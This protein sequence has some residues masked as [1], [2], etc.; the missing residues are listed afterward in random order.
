VTGHPHSTTG[1]WLF[2]QATS[3]WRDLSIS[4]VLSVFAAG[5]AVIASWLM[6][7]FGNAMFP[8]SVP[9]DGMG[10]L[11]DRLFTSL[12]GP[13]TPLTLVSL[14][15]GTYLAKNLFEY[16][17]RALSEAASL[18][19]E[20]RIRS[21]TWGAIW[22]NGSAHASGDISHAL[23][24]DSAEAASA[25]AVGPA[26][27]VG[28]PLTAMGYLL[29]LFWISP[30]L[31]GVL[32]V[33]VPAGLLL[34]RR[35]VRS[36]ARHADRRARSRAALGAAMTELLRFTRV[37]NAHWQ[38]SWAAD[39]TDHHERTVVRSATQWMLRVR[40]VPAVAEALAAFA[41]ALL[42]WLGIRAIAGGG[43][44][45]SE[46]L[47]FLTALFLLLPVVK[48]L[49]ALTGDL[50]TALSA[51]ER[52]H[53][54]MS[55]T[56]ATRVTRPLSRPVEI[57][58]DS[59]HVA[60]G[61]QSILNGVSFTADAG[62]MLAIHGPTGAGKTVLLEV[63]AGLRVPDSG[64]V[65]WNGGTVVN[66]DG[67]SMPS[68]VG[69]VPQDS[70]AVA[71]TIAENVTL[72][73]DISEDDVR[74]ALQWASLD[75]DPSLS[76]GEGGKPLSGG[77]RQRLAIARALAG[78]PAVLILDEPTS[79][80]DTRTTEAVMATLT[81]AGETTVIISSHDQLVHAAADRTLRLHDGRILR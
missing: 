15:C 53:A 2:T 30:G 41:G 6:V 77:E 62:E 19:I 33:I 4:L 60:D 65:T 59:L 3:Q 80:L 26:R 71:G 21:K 73:R 42:I 12:F 58:V 14:L 51:A 56:Q 49:G 32:L 24:I 5:V 76:I 29:T 34:T 43:V 23:L 52:L 20:S 66:M 16:G 22:R 11:V 7:P 31:S 28:D 44:A 50:R 81:L 27:M 55:A 39:R 61:T 78:L 69:Y 1:R 70:W 46:F 36:I 9:T 17:G 72:G 25:L 48:R 63:L 47:T 74:R 13:M 35:S 38:T 75:V 68:P 8:G 45:G 57:T 40:A 18:R 10:G 64:E 79:A 54:H 67:A 37:L